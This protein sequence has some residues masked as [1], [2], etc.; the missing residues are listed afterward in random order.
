MHRFEI[1]PYDEVVSLMPSLLDM[2]LSE[3]NPHPRDARVRFVEE[4]HRYYIDGRTDGWTSV[5]TLIHDNFE[6]FDAD[7]IISKMMN[8]R[9]WPD[10]KYFGMTP[11]EIKQAWDDNRDQAAT[12]GTAMHANVE[13]Y[14]NGLPHEVESKE[15]GMFKAFEADHPWFRPFRSEMIVFSTRI[16]LAG[17]VDMLYDD[18]R[19]PGTLAVGDWKRSKEIKKENKWQSGNT[20]ETAHLPDCNLVHYSLQLNIY[21][22]LLESVYG[23]K[24]GEKF[25]VVLHPNQDA[26]M[27]VDA[28]DLKAEA[29]AI[30]QKRGRVVCGK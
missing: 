1:H 28:L 12:A 13:N 26:Y 27:R 29:D 15:F 4:T 10:S 14:Y 2:L 17:S 21:S 11:E 7:K 24:I 5:T 22:I 9:K 8:S 18:L 25:L 19:N 16:K 30:L 20:A 6:H 3:V 23:F